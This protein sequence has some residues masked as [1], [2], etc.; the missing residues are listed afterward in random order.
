MIALRPFLSRRTG[1]GLVGFYE[2]RLY[3]GHIQAVG[4]RYSPRDAF[5]TRTSVNRTSLPRTGIHPGPSKATPALAFDLGPVDRQTAVV[6]VGHVFN[7]DFAGFHVHVYFHNLSRNSRK[8]AK[9]PQPRLCK[10]RQVWA[11]CIYPCRPVCRPSDK[12][13]EPLP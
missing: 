9:S 3:V 6:S 13:S 7:R 10:S 5:T 8:A 1:F 4:I 2:D 11:V 12:P